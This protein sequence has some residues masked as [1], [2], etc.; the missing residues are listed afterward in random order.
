MLIVFYLLAAGLVVVLLAGIYTVMTYNRFV[1]LKTTV[2]S[3][4][5]DV[6][7][8]LTKRYNLIPNLVETVK[9]YAG[10]E[11]GVFE[12]VTAL[13][14]RALQATSVDEKARCDDSLRDLFKSLFAVAENYPALKADANFQQLQKTLQE[15]ENNIE[16]GRRYYNAAV[17]EHNILLKSF[18]ANVVG[19]VFGL[20]VQPFFES[21]GEQVRETPRVDLLRG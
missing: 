15:L 14:S 10:Y 7:V 16:S 2:E 17:R 1:R 9:G 4:L 12:E 21:A 13:R 5:S 20:V 3:A 8:H 11:S 6:D 18:P 19:R